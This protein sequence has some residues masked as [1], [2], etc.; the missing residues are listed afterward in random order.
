MHKPNNLLE[1]DVREELDWDGVLDDSRIVVTAKDGVVT[2][3]GTVSS[4]YD[5]VVAFEDTLSVS[6]VSAVG[7]ELL[8]GP[9]G[10]AI[11]DVD[12]ADDCSSALDRDRFVPKGAVSVMVTD[13]WA[14][15]SGAVRRHFQRQAA[16]H[17]VQRVDGV[18]GITNKIDITSDLIPSDVVA[19]IN[20]A[21]GRNAMIDDSL[22][23][24]SNS[25]HTIYL[26]GTASSWAAKREAED[27]SWDAPGV[28][29]V[30]N[31]IVV[32]P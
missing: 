2:L 8:V 5:S 22:I 21:L 9:L 32:A 26:D 24:V 3:S 15:L 16:E 31:R 12:I 13:G 18:L 20:K 4:Y 30:V 25:R 14:T 19:S 29:D 10:E 1:A 6:G 28:N 7:N 27:V 23:E 17:A 11:A